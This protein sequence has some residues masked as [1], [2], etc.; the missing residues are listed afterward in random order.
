LHLFDAEL[1]RMPD[2]TFI[3]E[4]LNFR[5]AVKQLCEPDPKLRGHP[6]N[7]F[8]KVDQYGVERFISQFDIDSKKMRLHEK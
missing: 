3:T 2:G 6:L 8:R 1:P 5:T 4:A 7:V